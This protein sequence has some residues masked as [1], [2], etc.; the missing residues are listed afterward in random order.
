MHLD[1][2]QSMCDTQWGFRPGCF[3]VLALLSTVTNWLEIM[4]SGREICVV[5]LDYQESLWQCATWSFM[6]KLRSIRSLW[7][8]HNVADWLPSTSELTGCGGRC[9]VCYK[10]GCF[11]C[12]SRLTLRSTAC[13]SSSTCISTTWWIL[14]YPVTLSVYSMQRIFGL[15]GLFQLQ[16]T[17]A[18]YNL[19]ENV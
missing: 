14:D 8:T 15:T 17:P 13:S 1:I 12:A 19:T 5:F 2:Y 3:T 16:K 18:P 6:V 11:W 4:E 7:H 9:Q 10:F